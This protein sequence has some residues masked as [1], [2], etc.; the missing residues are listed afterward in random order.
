MT[1]TTK[2]ASGDVLLVE[3]DG[4]IAVLTLNRPESR[5]ALNGE[6]RRALRSTITDLDDNPDVRAIVVTG[7]DPAF[8]AGLDLREL[9]QASHTGP[10]D[11]ATEPQPPIGNTTTPV[12]GAIN[13]VAVTG[14]LELALNCDILIASEAARFADT[15]ARVGLM[16]WWGLSYLL[17]AAIGYSRAVEMSLSGNF[18]DAPTALAWGLVNHVVPHADLLATATRLAHDMASID[19][20]A[21][22]RLLETYREGR[23]GSL[24]EPR[25][26]EN[27]VARAWS[28]QMATGAVAANVDKVIERGRSQVDGSAA[29]AD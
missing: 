23:R 29:S 18:I 13:G 10:V 21:S 14:G 19:G 9:S 20:A 28:K 17:P 15:H 24:A 12:I 26:I 25:R 16:P 11:P 8:C 4:N 1:G 6:L 5:N 22:A 2:P 27:E 7:A 3:R